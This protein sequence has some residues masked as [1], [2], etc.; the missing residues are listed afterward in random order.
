MKTQNRILIVDDDP[1]STRLLE[2]VFRGRYALRMASSGEEALRV[3]PKFRPGLI[4]LDIDMPGIGGYETCRRIK[5]DEKLSLIKVL[6]VSGHAKLEE[7]LQGYEVGA[8]DYVAKPFDNSELR[9]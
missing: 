4:L 3:I 1:A 6:L 5:S 7:R 2:R 9:A 8:D